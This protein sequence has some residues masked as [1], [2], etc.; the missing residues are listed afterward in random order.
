MSAHERLKPVH[1][2][3]Y[4]KSPFSCTTYRPL[5]TLR[6]SHLLPYKLGP[7]AEPH[8]VNAETIITYDNIFVI[9]E[10]RRSPYQSPPR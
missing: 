2:V 9:Y 6:R 7:R 8:A 4:G 3:R 10:V 1:K 5:R